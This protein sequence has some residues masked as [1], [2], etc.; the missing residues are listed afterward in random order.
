MCYSRGGRVHLDHQ[1]SAPQSFSRRLQR[2][3]QLGLKEENE[4]EDP[5]DE[6]Q[7]WRLEEQ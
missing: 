5:E 4:D 1:I 2:S 3:S 7:Y 6:E